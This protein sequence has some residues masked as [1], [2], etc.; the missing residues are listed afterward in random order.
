MGRLLVL[1][2]LLRTGRLALRLLRDERVPL[3][4][5]AVPA[6]ALLYVVLPLDIIPDFIPVIGQLDDLAALAAGLS[7][8]IR[9]CPA[10]VVEE[11]ELAL[12][13]RERTTVEG[14][15]RPIPPAD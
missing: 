4:A 1:K 9:L 3:Y 10:E 13:W 2:D 8:F 12:G 15:A 11:H 6:V 5:K 14:Q 7:L